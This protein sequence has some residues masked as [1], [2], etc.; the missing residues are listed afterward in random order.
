MSWVTII[1]SMIA[2]ACLTLAAMHLLIWYKKRTA[3]ASLVFAVMAVSTAALSGLELWGMRSETPQEY[4]DILRWAHVPYWVLIISLVVFVRVYMRAGRSWLAWTVCAVRT[5][6]LLLN[7]L[8]GQNLNYREVTGLR[9]V[10][11]FGESVSVAQ[12]VANPWMLVGQLSLLLLVIFVADATFAVWRRGDRR[13]LVLLG[14]TIIFFVMGGTGMFVMT[15]WGFIHIPIT[16][17][18]FFLGIVVV[19]GYELSLEAFRAAGLADDLRKREEWL[20]LAADSAGVGLWLWDFKTNLLWITEKTRMLYGISSQGQVS[21]ETFLSKLHPDDLD[22][23]TQAGRKCS[24]EGE[25]FRYDYRIVTPDGSIRWLK[26]LAKS[27]LGPSGKPERMTGVSLDITERKQAEQEN[28][29]KRNELAYVARISTMNQLA[30]S[31]AH[32]LNQPLGAIMRNA[33]AGE[34]FLQDP[35]PDLDEIR[36]IL[37]DIRKDNQRAGAVIDRMRS[38]LKRRE[39]EHSL[40]D[41]NLLA[42][43]VI[44]LVCPE[45]DARKVRIALNP[46]SSLP[47]VRGDRVQFQQVLLNLLLNAMD[48]MN[49]TAPDDRRIT[50]LVQAAGRQVE[51]AVSDAGH[52]IPADKL[53]HVFEPFFSTK[54]NGLGMGLAISRSIIEAHRGSIRAKNNEPAGATFTITL[55]SAEGDITK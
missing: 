18:L 20:D 4:A 10:P 5:F 28:E 3:W 22:W 16:A 25:D 23:V 49:D 2:S 7:F 14:S 36:A 34:L 40:L 32:E 52:G 38:Q 24:Q 47:P 55:P 45:A 19:M 17:S 13:R 11:Y 42:S 21:F 41:L 30:S 46:V 8:V 35:S 48:A 50:M 9:H 15:F 12:G 26:V 37:A 53:S 29:Q 6:S 27:F 44:A 39:V 43:E 33:E 51:V 1:W 54:P 31:L